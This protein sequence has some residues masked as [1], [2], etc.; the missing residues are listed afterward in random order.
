MTASK[1]PIWL[2]TAGRKLFFSAY[3]EDEKL[4]GEWEN[5]DK[6]DK[7]VKRDE[8]FVAER[9]IVNYVNVPT[10]A[11]PEIAHTFLQIAQLF[12]ERVWKRIFTITS[13]QRLRNLYK[14]EAQKHNDERQDNS[15]LVP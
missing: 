6:S 11:D 12:F 7:F 3:K 14:M 1:S 15:H 4:R 10:A 9:K 13:V 8:I 5:N 2:A